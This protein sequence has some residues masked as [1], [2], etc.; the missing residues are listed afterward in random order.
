MTE[1]KGIGQR[2]TDSRAEIIMVIVNVYW[3]FSMC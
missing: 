1:G 2:S 3:V